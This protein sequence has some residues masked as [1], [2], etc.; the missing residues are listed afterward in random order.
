MRRGS[1]WLLVLGCLSACRTNVALIDTAWGEELRHQGRIAHVR[2]ARTPIAA[3]PDGYRFVL[4]LVL[5]NDT[6]LAWSV[7]AAELSVRN[8]G[9]PEETEGLVPHIDL[10]TDCVLVTV[11]ARDDASVRLPIRIDCPSATT[12]IAL[13][14]LPLELALAHDGQTLL[15]RRV[16][17]GSYNQIGQA[18]RVVFLATAGLVLLSLL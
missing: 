1:L 9:K 5:E 2:S 11:P 18:A 4:D 17:A 6:D 16:V 7:R 3:T 8:L 13:E 15:R 10:P 14:R 12:A